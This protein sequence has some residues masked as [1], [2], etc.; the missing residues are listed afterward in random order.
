MQANSKKFCQVT[1]T[2]C[3]KFETGIEKIVMTL[4]DYYNFLDMELENAKNMYN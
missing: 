1:L 3:V 4:T 2:K